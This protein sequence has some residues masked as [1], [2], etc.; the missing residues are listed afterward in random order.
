[1]PHVVAVSTADVTDL[2]GALQALRPHDVWL[3]QA[4]GGQIG[5]ML[6][7]SLVEQGSAAEV[8]SQPWHA[9]TRRLLAA[10]PAN[11]SS[12]KAEQSAQPG[13]GDVVVRARGVVKQLGGQMLLGGLNTEVRRG[14]FIAVTG[15]SGSGKTTLGN[16][17]LGLIKPDQGSIERAAGLPATAL[18]A[19]LSR[20]GGGICAGHHVTAFTARSGTTASS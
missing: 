20:S 18:Q 19:D 3:A 9:Y 4:L 1:L 10:D 16:L 7:G 11:W 8:L 12:H 17:M 2:K 15:P 13:T 6:D 14:E 5:V